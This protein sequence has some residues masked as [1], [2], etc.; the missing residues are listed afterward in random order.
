MLLFIEVMSIWDVGIGVE[1]LPS[2]YHQLVLFV[3]P[4]A[5]L[6]PLRKPDNGSA[7]LL[8]EKWSTLQSSMYLGWQ[9]PLINESDEICSYEVPGAV[10]D[11][12]L[13]RWID[14]GAIWGHVRDEH[15]D[16]GPSSRHVTDQDIN[17]FVEDVWASETIYPW[18]QL[19]LLALFRKWQRKRG[20]EG[21]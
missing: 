15:Y 16:E 11:G 4:S 1:L 12:I 20:R 18:Q 5:F 2:P 8:R 14:E 13:R 10:A 21:N 17:A 3:K 19:Y 7:R 9:N 6:L